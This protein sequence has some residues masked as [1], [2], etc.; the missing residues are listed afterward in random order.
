M[1]LKIK[2]GFI[3]VESADDAIKS[4]EDVKRLLG[5]TISKEDREREKIRTATF[6]GAK[7]TEPRMPI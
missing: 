4:L 6:I 5:K 2:G 3:E 1:I 7:G